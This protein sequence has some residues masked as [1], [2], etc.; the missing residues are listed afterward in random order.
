[1][2]E[3]WRQTWP[4]TYADRL[5]RGAVNAMLTELD[6]KGVSSL[7]DPGSSNAVCAFYRQDLIGTAIHS[8]GRPVAYLWAMYVMPSHQKSGVGKLLLE[9][10]RD[11]VGRLPIQVRVL[12]TSISAV[13]FYEKNGF[14][15]CWKECAEIMPGTKA[16]CRVM[17]QL[18]REKASSSNFSHWRA[19][20][21]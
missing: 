7:Y 12:Q 15:L 4:R 6:K 9:T 18:Q 8:I 19:P 16:E 21:E 14:Q 11:N 13:R 3:V 20:E 2:I 10:V 1:M 5:G 17:Q